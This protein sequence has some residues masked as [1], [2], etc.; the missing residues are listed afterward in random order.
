LSRTIELRS[1]SK[2]QEQ[3]LGPRIIHLIGELIGKISIST[4]NIYL[5][6]GKGL[7]MNTDNICDK[8]R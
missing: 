3:F 8:N 5:V 6:K 1:T 4:P 7:L 2:S